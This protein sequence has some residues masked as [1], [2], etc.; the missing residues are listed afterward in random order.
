VN[1]TFLR[2]FRIPVIMFAMYLKELTLQGFKTFAQKTTLRF[3]D[4]TNKSHALTAIVGPN[5][6]G[7]SNVADAIRW[8]LGEQ[9][10]KLLRSKSSAD[11][12]FSGSNGKARSG[13]AEVELTFADVLGIE[14]IDFSEVRITRKLYRDGE[15]LYAINGQSVRL[16]DVQMFLAQANVGQKSYSV[17]GQGQI[18][19]ILAASPEERKS[20]FDD[21]TGVKPLQ[22]KRH[23]ASLKLRRTRDNLQQA[24]LLIQEIEPRLRTLRRLVKRLHQREDVEKALNESQIQYYGTLWNNLQSQLHTELKSFQHIEKIVKEQ[25]CELE[26]ER[27]T[28]KDLESKK[29]NEKDAPS[30]ELMEL[31]KR[32]DVLQ[33]KRADIRE[34]LYEAQKHLELAQVRS[35]STWTP[36][37]LSQIISR[38][39][40]VKDATKKIKEKWVKNDLEEQDIDSAFEES[41]TLLSRLQKPA[42][43]T[44]KPDPK[45]VANLKNTQKEE[46]QLITE[47]TALK[48]ALHDSAQ[49][50]K[51]ERTEFF[52]L[53]NRLLAAQDK[54]HTLESQLNERRVALARLETRNEDL[55]RDMKEVLA[56]RI[57]KARAYEDGADTDS[58]YQ[59]IQQL[60]H[61]LELIGGIDEETVTEFEETQERF[62][63]LEQQ[64]ADLVGALQETEKL[65]VELDEQISSQSKKAFASIQTHFEHYF[66][67]LF[68]GGTCSL[69]EIKEKDVEVESTEKSDTEEEELYIKKTKAELE[70]VV[71][72]DI[73]ATPPGK[74]L[75]S[76]NLLSGGERAL[77]SIAL[78]SAIM[79]TNPSPFVVLDEVDAALDEAN[80][81]RFS[82]ILEDLRSLTQFIIITHNR[83]TMHIADVIYGVSMQQDGVSQLLSLQLE[84]I[85]TEKKTT[86]A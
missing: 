79:A 31:Q 18:D 64:V 60:R 66:K 43:E 9:S 45:H 73:Q 78:I 83:A 81:V 59:Q 28:L 53:Q 84:Q 19:H 15:S 56:D 25:A 11:V 46:A 5:G 38:I 48:Q 1:Y 77:T 57:N 8:V 76:I 86:K 2:N 80:T 58:L 12:I 34:R 33:E 51:N 24:E 70:R 54:L 72:I 61:K 22:L 36:L 75:K 6:S 35:T 63:H 82:K 16:S 17:V 21:A 49:S 50:S 3:L 74:R 55:E 69:K 26:A 30:E 23:R 85:R 4:P 47:L 62:T 52:A 42:P 44:H 68:G 7:K 20:F 29:K 32:Y 13:V 71:G 67:I 10:M 40:S 27:E 65:I 37:P 41:K 39:T 14:G